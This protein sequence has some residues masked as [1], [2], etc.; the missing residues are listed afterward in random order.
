MGPGLPSA[1]S[2]SCTVTATTTETAEQSLAYGTNSCLPCGSFLAKTTLV[3]RGE[4]AVPAL[5]LGMLLREKGAPAR[6]DQGNF[7]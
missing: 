6:V 5:P 7:S 2:G 1:F 4:V 3:K